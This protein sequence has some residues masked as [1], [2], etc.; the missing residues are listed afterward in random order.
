MSK[1]PDLYVDTIQQKVK[2]LQIL[3]DNYAAADGN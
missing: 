3:T 1:L 2:Q